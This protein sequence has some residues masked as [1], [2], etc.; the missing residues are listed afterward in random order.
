MKKFT[1]LALVTV[2]L[3]QMGIATAAS[4][5]NPYGTATVDPAAPNE[6]IFSITKGSR[7]ADFAYPRLLKLKHSTISIYEP[8]LKRRETF[9]VI[10]LQTLFTFVG[11]AGA[12]KVVTKALNDYI[13]TSTAAKFIVADAYLAIKKNGAAIGYDQGGPIRI[14]FP[15]DSPWAKNLDAWNWSIATIT[16]R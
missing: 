5:K 11:I 13:F 8:F 14:I 15:D 12:D 3:L 6:I 2:L 16:A 10:K 7:K 1:L 9:T 4:G